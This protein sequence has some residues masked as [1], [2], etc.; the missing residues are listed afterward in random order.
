[1]NGKVLNRILKLMIYIGLVDGNFCPG[2]PYSGL[3]DAKDT[4]LLSCRMI[5]RTVSALF[6]FKALYSVK[7]IQVILNYRLFFLLRD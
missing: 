3:M 2:S 7:I 5:A 1:M 4:K 6:T